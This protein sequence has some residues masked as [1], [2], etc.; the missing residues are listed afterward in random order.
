MMLQ[1]R[2]GTTHLGTVTSMEV[3]EARISLKG[4]KPNARP[5]RILDVPG[6]PRLRSRAFDE[7][8]NAA[9]GIVFLVDAVDFMPKK[10]EVAE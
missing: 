8:V 3:N 4:D 2:D 9:R 5:A 10:S 1:L 6:H 7:H